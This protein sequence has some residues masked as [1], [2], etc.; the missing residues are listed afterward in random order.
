MKHGGSTVSGEPPETASTPSSSTAEANGVESLATWSLRL[1]A[2]LASSPDAGAGLTNLCDEIRRLLPCDRVQIWRGDLRQMAMH[3]VIAAGFPPEHAADLPLQVVP[4]EA[5]RLVREGFLESKVA[6]VPRADALDP[7]EARLMLPFGIRSALFLLLERGTHV[8]GALQLSWCDPERAFVPDP[9]VVDLIRMHTALGVDFLARTTDATELSQNLSDTATL[10]ARIHDP[11]E[12]LQAMAAKVAHAIGC[13]WAAVHLYDESSRVMRRVAIHGSSEPGINVPAGM[14]AWM[15]REFAASPE[16]V[17]EIPDTDALGAT[18]P[19]ARAIRMSSCV[20]VP[21]RD[22][23]QLLGILSAGYR[24]RRGRFARRQMSLLKGLARHAQVALVN[25]QLV[26]SLEEANRV[27]SD[28][29]A[30]VSHD[31]RTP[32]HVLIGYNSMLLEDACGALN[33]EQ[34]A[35]VERMYECSVHFLDLINGVLGLGRVEAGFDRVM[36]TR[37]SLP[38]LADDIRREVEYL[39]RPE[40]ELRVRADAVAVSS[41]AAKLATILR[42]LV[43]NA[44]KFTVDGF[45]EVRLEQRD[46]ELRMIVRDTG[47]GIAPEERPK[48]FEMFRQGAA[49]LRAGGS[50][51]GLGLYL[52]QRLS[53]M[54]GGTVEL[55]SDDAGTTRF[56]VRVPAA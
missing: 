21:L 9:I 18:V 46:G 14:V 41:D 47:P 35:L 34:R 43:T 33:D 55:T 31:L 44:L 10:L 19:A 38:Q 3:S 11:D 29:V 4:I 50:G 1:G 7:D 39:R 25:A 13:D 52:V 16:G 49:G 42:N 27:K 53:A 8:L 37:V 22:D 30:A 5:L 36:R 15:E 54:L 6:L 56:E 23:T 28:F 45:V 12:L 17:L 2:A 20:A 40:V 51:L 26:R 24:E 32:L 48:V